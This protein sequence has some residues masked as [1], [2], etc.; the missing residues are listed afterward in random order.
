MTGAQH[1]VAHRADRGVVRPTLPFPLSSPPTPA[2]PRTLT[3]M[4]ALTNASIALG[5]TFAITVASS[6]AAQTPLPG[7]QA[8][9]PVI[10]SEGMSFKVDNPT[11]EVPAGHV[12]QAVW[13]IST[14]GGDS[15]RI[16]QQLVTIAR[17]YNAHVRNG[18][19]EERLKAA[20]VFHGDGWTA[21]LSD[22]AF[23]ARFGGKGNPSKGLVQ[24]LLQHGAQLVLC[25]QTAG[26]RGIH[27]EELLPGVR[28][29]VS[30]MAAFNVL[31]AQGYQYNPW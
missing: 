17:F 20:A 24:E 31:Q 8:S 16:N 9:G 14:G 13:I 2:H 3:H 23:I 22:S 25:G 6:L 7:R 30:A 10:N 26:S 15:T 18:F 29:A 1:R 19:A 12:F 5:L 28:V 27:R 11:F 21:L 4:R